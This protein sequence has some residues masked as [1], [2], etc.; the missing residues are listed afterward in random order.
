M[1]MQ[2]SFMELYFFT[3]PCVLLVWDIV[4]RFMINEKKKTKKR[5][6]SDQRY[7][8]FL[9]LLGCVVAPLILKGRLYFKWDLKNHLFKYNMRKDLHSPRFYLNS[10]VEDL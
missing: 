5:L 9:H 3:I 10:I 6:T 2:L 4:T 7:I 1:I 8:L